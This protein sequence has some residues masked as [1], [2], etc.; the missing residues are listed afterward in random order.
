MTETWT[1]FRFGLI[2]QTWTCSIIW[3]SWDILGLMRLGLM[4]L[5]QTHGTD[6]GP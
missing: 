1:W 2:L 5:N 3:D 6:L 4:V